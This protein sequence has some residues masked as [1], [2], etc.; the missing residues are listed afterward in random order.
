MRTYLGVR[1][2]KPLHK[3]FQEIHKKMSD[4]IDRIAFERLREIFPFEEPKGI[5]VE[6][7]QNQLDE[8]HKTIPRRK[9]EDD[10]RNPFPLLRFRDGI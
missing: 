3:A 9:I 7:L 4:E 2:N 5:T 10:Y 8:I 1:I 6:E